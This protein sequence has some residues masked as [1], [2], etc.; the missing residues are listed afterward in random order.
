MK[1]ILRYRAH[2]YYT[3]EQFQTMIKLS[4]R[5]SLLVRIVLMVCFVLLVIASITLLSQGELETGILLLAMTLPLP[6]FEMRL[7][8]YH[9]RQTYSFQDEL[10]QLR[11]TI[12]FYD[13]YFHEYDDLSSTKADYTLIDEIYETSLSIFVCLKT[14]QYVMISKEG[15]DQKLVSFLQEKKADKKT[16]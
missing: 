14:R 2:T 11:R 9:L 10:D 15:A 4:H 5:R 6:I 12:D 3:K 8:A 13:D 1:Q 7:Y 16:A